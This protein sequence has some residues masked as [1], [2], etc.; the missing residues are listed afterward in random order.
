MTSAE[1]NLCEPL[2]LVG[3]EQARV[4]DMPLLLALVGEL[5]GKHLGA[6]ELSTLDRDESRYGSLDWARQYARSEQGLTAHQVNETLSSVL[7]SKSAFSAVEKREDRRMRWG[8]VACWSVNRSSWSNLLCS[9]ATIFD[10]QFQSD[11][12]LLRCAIGLGRQMEILHATRM[13]EGP[14]DPIIALRSSTFL[15]DPVFLDRVPARVRAIFAGRGAEAWGLMSEQRRSWARAAG[16]VHYTPM[17]KSMHLDKQENVDKMPVQDAVAKV[18][19]SGMDEVW[20]SLSWT[21]HG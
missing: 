5:P 15:T 3:G 14:T 10:S 6:R 11:Y 21:V 2:I 9:A 13:Q 8:W 19:L 4:T 18:K 20:R 7:Q 16:V 12:P 17:F 1:S